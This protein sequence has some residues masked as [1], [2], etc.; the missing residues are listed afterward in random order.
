ML[1]EPDDARADDRGVEDDAARDARRDEVTRARLGEEHRRRGRSRRACGPTARASARGTAT[2]RACRRRRR[3]RPAGR[4]AR[5]PRRRA[6]PPA[7]PAR[8]RPG[9]PTRASP[10]R[11]T[12]ASSSP[13][14]Q[15]D[16]RDAR[17]GCDERLGAGE[18]DPALR[19]GDE[20]DLPS[21]RRGPLTRSAIDGVDLD[22]HVERQ[23]RHADRRPR[24]EPIRPV[25][26]EHEIREAVDHGR[27]LGEAVDGVDEAVDLQPARDAVEA[28][29]LALDR[30][31][32]V[33]RGQLRRRDGLLDRQLAA[34]LAELR[35][36]ALAVGRAV[37]RRCTR[38]RRGARAAGR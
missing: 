33:E 9:A 3:G 1:F 5:R 13:S 6:R 30:A 11:A 38:R 34:D 20:R 31:E 27:V 35:A 16:A 22:R 19:P 37:A 32:H 10:S 28:A 24:R 14:G 2:G 7:R 23:V 21:S 8:G 29:E 26:V 12:A 4:A 36:P 15:V 25:E 17:A 18:A